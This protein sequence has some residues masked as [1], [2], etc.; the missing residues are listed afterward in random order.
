[1]KYDFG[2][3]A[4]RANLKCSDGRVIM[5]DA[6]KNNDGQKVP[7]VWQHQRNEPNN[8]IGYA[9]LENRPDG[10]YAYG[11]FNDTEN[12]KTAKTLVEHGDITNL[13]IYA[14]RLSQ[15]GPAV[16]HGMIREVSLVMAGANPGAF[17]ENLSVEHGD[18]DY[19]IVDD[20]A[21]IYTN[22]S[23]EHTDFDD[24]KI[25]MGEEDMEHADG[26]KTVKEVFDSMTDEQK[27]VCY[28]LIGQALEDDED[29]EDVEQSD[30]DDDD[31][32]HEDGGDGR[33]NVFESQNRTDD[34]TLSHEET[35]A[36]FDDMKRY[37]SLKESALQHG[38]TN[39]DYLFPDPK[40]VNNTPSMIMRQQDWVSKVWNAT[41]K[42]P[43]SRIKSSAANLTEEEAR[44]K[45]Y[46]KGKLKKEEQFSLLKRVTLP[47]TVYKKQKLDRDDII[48]ITDFDVVGWLKAEMRIML[49][50]ELARAVLI[51][52]GR[53]SSSEDKINPMNIR[54]IW[55]DEDLYT[56]HYD[57]H[58]LDSAKSGG[59]NV[60][61]T[62]DN[63]VTLASRFVD[64]F[65]EGANRSRK[66][67]KGSGSPTAYLSSDTLTELLLAKDKIGRRLYN[68][69]AELASALRVS[70]IVEV[71]LMEG[72][73]RIASD[74]SSYQLHGLIVNLSDYTV[75]A[76]KGGAVSMFDD[77]DIDYNQQK[78][79]IETRCSGALTVPYSAIALETSVL[80]SENTVSK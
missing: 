53:L 27:N 63:A 42:S 77:F 56:I 6:F 46:I 65:I 11:K 37:G 1:M 34:N 41:R 79:L 60:G 25:K 12:G 9:L 76:D 5:K 2:G 44:A 45:G 17:I 19:E 80:Q 70:E 35:Q 26:N 74:G 78:Y 3:Y 36:I 8:V 48:D 31:F 22:S 54:P 4:T 15:N 23:I 58:G 67:Y 49:N 66:N 43:F 71:P 52:D 28:F 55:T 39:I 69:V 29:D 40:L 62:T 10:V 18:G 21:V 13:S 20:E 38:I 50:E 7:L 33:M 14:N 47:Q 32:E 72:Q 59:S 64:S 68:T 57:I 16:K 51:G 73:I 30:Y 24:E 75:G 61:G